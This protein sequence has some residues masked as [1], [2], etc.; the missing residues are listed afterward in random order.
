MEDHTEKY[1]YLVFTACVLCIV[2]ILIVENMPVNI[3]LNNN[4]IP[5]PSW[6]SEI[7]GIGPS[8]SETNGRF[9]FTLPQ[10]S[11]GTSDGGIGGGLV[12]EF[13]LRGDFDVQVNYTLIE[14]PISN[15]V[16]AGIGARSDPLSGISNAMERTSFSEHDYLSNRENYV[17]DFGNPIITYTNDTSGTLRIVRS[18]STWSSYY[19]SGGVWK[20]HYQSSEGSTPD[21]YIFLGAWSHDS[22]FIHK[23]VR[24]A[25]DNFVIN[26]GHIIWSDQQTTII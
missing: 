15:G 19:F 11:T 1:L 13:G 4:I 5:F 23:T 25:L 3:P 17:T 6:R 26:K 24:V 16:R 14:W 22:Y 8:I 21:A 7:T 2:I 9:I 18:G 12:S 20:L 10:D